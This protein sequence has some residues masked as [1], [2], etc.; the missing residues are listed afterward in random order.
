M[1][2]LIWIITIFALAVGLSML[3][4][5]DW[6]YVQFVLPQHW[7]LQMPA[8]FFAGALLAAF[9]AAYLL[10]RLIRNTL[11][12]PEVVGQW[13]ERRR[14][15]RADRSLREAVLTLHEGRYAR[16]L[17]FAEKAYE[18]SDQPAAAILLAARAAHALRDDV[19]YREWIGRL[20]DEEEG[21]QMARLM[22][23]AELAVIACDFEEAAAKL[24]ALRPDGRRH[25]AALRLSLRVSMAL[26][27]WDE[28]LHLIRLLRKHKAL[29][30]EQVR[31]LLCRVHVERLRARA[32]EFDAANDGNDDVLTGIW[33]S[34]PAEEREDRQLVLE[35][36]PLFARLGKGRIV[37]RTLERLLD[38]EWDT[39][40]ARLYGFCGDVGACLSKGEN[41][42]LDHR[43]DPGLLFSLGRLCAESQ[44]WGK[45]V[46]YFELSL[47][48]QPEVETHLALANLFKRLERSEDEQK[49]YRAAAE[50][51][52]AW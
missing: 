4:S 6:G 9:M 49:H 13:R 40:L 43:E 17:K 5:Q 30:D 39:G 33:D 15:Q 12:L 29:T 22:T 48:W 24:D 3:I 47:R 36:V 14:R 19:R 34:I 10:V 51:I 44:L 2:V 46:E 21:V 18:A 31:P 16:A 23:E 41:W 28:S 37:R 32:D 45:A 26:W 38:A 35:A 42:L 20:G 11:T 8:K 50:M 27:Q 52:A 25:I 1:R 7:R